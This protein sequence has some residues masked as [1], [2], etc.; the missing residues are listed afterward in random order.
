MS[1]ELDTIFVCICKKAFI[2]YPASNDELV[3]DNLGALRM[4][5][6]ALQKE[7]A[8]DYVRAEQLWEK[9]KKLLADEVE[10]ETGVGAINQIRVSDDFDV[11]CVPNDSWGY[12]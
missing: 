3:I 8:G 7:D 12:P 6:E 9:A 10:D 4:G 11:A 2:L 5:L 1:A